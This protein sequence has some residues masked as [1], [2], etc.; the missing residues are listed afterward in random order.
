LID[1]LNELA[2]PVAEDQTTFF[3]YK[4]LTIEKGNLIEVANGFISTGAEPNPSV[5]NSKDTKLVFN[6]LNKFVKNQKIVPPKWQL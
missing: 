5:T 2:K 1:S 4:D 6:S 3:N